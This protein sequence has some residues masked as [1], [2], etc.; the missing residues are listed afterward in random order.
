MWT[1]YGFFNSMFPIFFTIMF[2]I[3]IGTFIVVAVR[4]ISE[5]SK[6]NNSPRLKVQAKVIAKRSCTSHH[7]TGP[8]GA[9]HMTTTY[10]ATFQ[11]ESGDRIELHVGPREYGMLAKGDTGT[12]EFQGTRYLSFTRS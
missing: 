8:N 10:F 2:V 7:N 6:N 1:M 11:V 5:W 4:G 3:V 9:M 12:L